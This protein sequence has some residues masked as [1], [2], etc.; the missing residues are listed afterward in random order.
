MDKRALSCAKYKG[1]WTREDITMWKIKERMAKG[2]QSDVEMKGRI[3][4]GAL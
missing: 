4:K 3:Q 1:G 2:W